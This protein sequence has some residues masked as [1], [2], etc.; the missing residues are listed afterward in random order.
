MFAMLA[1]VGGYIDYRRRLKPE[2]KRTAWMWVILLYYLVMVPLPLIMFIGGIG[3]PQSS[4]H[5]QL[6][7]QMKAMQSDL[8]Q[9]VSYLF[10]LLASLVAA[11][12]MFWFSRFSVNLF[13]AILAMMIL[14]YV[15]IAS[16]DTG[17]WLQPA[18]VFAFAVT[19]SVI[20]YGRHLARAGVLQ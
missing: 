6:Q 10:I 16:H 4:V 7:A 14:R 17:Q 3:M 1:L 20:L 13:M 2:W 11:V 12:Y 15:V 9:F 8:F 5:T 19:I 18:A